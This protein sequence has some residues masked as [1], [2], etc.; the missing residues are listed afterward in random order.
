MAKGIYEPNVSQLISENLKKGDLFL[1][2]GA[3]VG[4]FCRIAAKKVEKTG[5]IFAFEADTSNYFALIK[6]TFTK[7]NTHPLHFAVSDQNGFLT[8]NHSNHSA[9][10]S[11]INTDN[12]LDG[13]QY[14]VPSITLDHFWEYYLQKKPIDLLK[15]DVEGAEIMVLNGMTKILSTQA[16]NTMIIEFC[17]EILKRAEFDLTETYHKLSSNFTIEIIEEEYKSLSNTATGSVQS[18]ND[19]QNISEQLIEMGDTININFL[20]RRK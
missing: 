15:I 13:K 17:P 4:Y 6:N 18:V 1:D 19:L 11:L 5:S 8:L 20:C 10:H 9:C 3:N 12:Y 2:V 16:V 7:E 14:T